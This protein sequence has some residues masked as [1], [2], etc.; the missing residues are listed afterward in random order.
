MNWT[1]NDGTISI[2]DRGV[3][4]GPANNGEADHIVVK[5]DSYPI[6]MNTGLD[7]ISRDRPEVCY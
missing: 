6:N 2:G 7:T 1:G 5:F 3:V 4:Q